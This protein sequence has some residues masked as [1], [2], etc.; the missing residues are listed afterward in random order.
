[1]SE[2]GIRWVG[3]DRD[4]FLKPNQWPIF[5]DQDYV[6][7]LK[8]ANVGDLLYVPM[9]YEVA[10]LLP[11]GGPEHGPTYS[12]ERF[13]YTLG[14]GRSWTMTPGQKRVQIFSQKRPGGNDRRYMLSVRVAADKIPKTLLLGE[15]LTVYVPVEKAQEPDPAEKLHAQMRDQER[16]LQ[17]TIERVGRIADIATERYS[18]VIQR[19]DQEIESARSI[20]QEVRKLKKPEEQK[21]GSMFR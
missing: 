13:I 18:K 5:T 19:L 6:A 14:S 9:A 8:S 16:Q 20:L 3:G 21:S 7:A 10:V 4:R 17:Q 11:V 2:G 15:E 12:K 1:M